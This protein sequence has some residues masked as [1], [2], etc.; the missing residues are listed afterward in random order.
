MCTLLSVYC[1]VY[2]VKCKVL[3]HLYSQVEKEL[4]DICQDILDV[5]DKHLIP[6]RCSFQCAVCS[7]QCAV[8]SVQCAVCSMQCVVYSM[9]CAVGSL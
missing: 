3:P 6:S 9:Q 4:R 2:T 8:C 1:K 7:V 5:L